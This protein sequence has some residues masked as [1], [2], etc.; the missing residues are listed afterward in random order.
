MRI[1]AFVDT[2][3]EANEL[4]TTAVR[5]VVVGY[6]GRGDSMGILGGTGSV[7]PRRVFYYHCT[8][9]GWT[10]EVMSQQGSPASTHTPTVQDKLSGDLIGWCW[11]LEEK[12]ETQHGDLPGETSLWLAANTRPNHINYACSP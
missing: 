5:C 7:T 11:K 3:T 8:G 4:G 9:L 12:R 10:N 1:F 2:D 6:V